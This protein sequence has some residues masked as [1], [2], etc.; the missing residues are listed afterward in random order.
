MDAN[1]FPEIVQFNGLQLVKNA[2]IRSAFKFT[3]FLHD[4]TSEAWNSSK[5]AFHCSFLE[6]TE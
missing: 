3:I 5:S 4:L 1:Q 6:T 2:N